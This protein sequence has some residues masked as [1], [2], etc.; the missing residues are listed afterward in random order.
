VKKLER[1]LRRAFP[2]AVIE[3]TGRSHFRLK[4]PN[5]AT[6]LV[7]VVF[8]LVGERARRCAPE[9]KEKRIRADAVSSATECEQQTP[10]RGVLNDEHQ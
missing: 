3:R 7:A 9:I 1:E 6:V 2:Q 10:Q 4:L 8:V 5:G